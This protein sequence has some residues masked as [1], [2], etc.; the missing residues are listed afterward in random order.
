MSAGTRLGAV[1]VDY[2][3]WPAICSTLDALLAGARAPDHVVVVDNAS[4]DGSAA[5]IRSRFPRIEVVEADANR[6]PA[7]AMN[8]GARR[9]AALGVDHLL[10]LTAECILA[11]DALDAL[12]ARLAEAPGVGVVGPL[13]ARTS[14]PE[15]VFSAGGFVDP[16]TWD[17]RHHRDPPQVRDWQGSPPQ[18]REW[19]DG[20]CL[21]VRA[22]AWRATG[23]LDE[24]YFHYFDDVDHH[25][26]MRSRGWKV[27]CVPAAV[28][29]QEP[30]VIAPDVWVRNRLR[31]LA[32]HGPRRVLARELARQAR[33][34]LR[35]VWAG[36]L[37][38]AAA[39][40]RGARLFLAGRWGPVSG[41]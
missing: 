27:E 15:T 11:P 40:A 10:L 13:L 39:R 21:L 9:L 1:V 12:E 29:W 17:P 23:P 26:R 38:R 34:G 3:A 5:A 28:A 19:L 33:H 31:F 18:P 41:R 7:A 30:G 2:R 24:E 6:G 22:D 25:V 20:A 16:S 4:G 14:A 36:D 37:H 8:L 32:R 35:D